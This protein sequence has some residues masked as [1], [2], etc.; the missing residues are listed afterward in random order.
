MLLQDLVQ[1]SGTIL[2]LRTAVT[3]IDHEQLQGV[4]LTRQQ[5][6]KRHL[7]PLLGPGVVLVGHALH[8]DLRALQLDHQPVIDTSLLFK[9]K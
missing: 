8:N 9:Y 7:L 4:T 3:G 1:P 2:D 5:L 6:L